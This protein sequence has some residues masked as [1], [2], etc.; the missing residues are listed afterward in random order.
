MVFIAVPDAEKTVREWGEKGILCAQLDKVRLVT[1]FQQ[2][3]DD[4]SY[5]LERITTA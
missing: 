3:D 2:T 5:V 4:I 1:H